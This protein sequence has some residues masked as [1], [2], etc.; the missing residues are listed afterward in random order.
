MHYKQGM[1]VHVLGAGPAGLY[2]AL[3]LKKAAPDVV[4]TVYERNAGGDTFGFGV[5]FSDETLSYLDDADAETAALIRAQFAHWTAVDT[6]FRGKTIR[7]EGH[8]FSGIERRE[9]LKILSDRAASLGAE[10]RFQTEVDPEVLLASL[11]PND[12]VVGADG[13]NSRLRGRLAETIVPTFDERKA[14]YIWLGTKQTFDAFVFAFAEHEAGLFQA[15]AYRF[16]GSR[17]DAPCSTF[18]VETSEETYQRAGLERMS[19]DAQ[20][21][22]L[23][24]LFAEHLGGHALE[25]NRSE[26]L[27][28][29]TLRC[30]AWSHKNVVFLGDAVH[31]AHF[32]IGSGTKLAMEDA[33]T[34]ARELG[35]L[36]RGKKTVAEAF[37]DYETERRLIVEKTQAAA[38]DSL[39]FFENTKRYAHFDP[40]QFV[41]R[42]MT[43][44]KRIGY[45]NLGL[46]DATYIDEVQS[47]FA[48]AAGARPHVP[49]M[50]TPYRL[51]EMAL[52]NRV[53]LSPMCMYRAESGT[54]GEAHLV[55]L[56]S[57]AVGGAGLLITE[58]TCPA[59]DA[60]ITPGCAGIY[61]DE[62][63][64]AWKRVVDFV[65]RESTTKICLQI[66]HAGR[67]GSTREP[68][69]G[70]DRPLSENNWP[71]IS[72]SAIAYAPHNQ[73]PREATEADLANV[74]ES[75]VE[76]TKRAELAGFD[77]I[78]LHAAHGYLLASF[79]SPLTNQRT[80]AYGGSIQNRVRYPLSVFQA[81][82]AVWP[83][84]KPMSV[85]ISATDWDDEGISEEDML[86]IATAFRDAGADILHVSTGQTTPDG[87]PL[88]Y[89]RM[90]QTPF[91]DQIRNETR[92]PT[93][94]VGNITTADQVN[95]ILA[96]G[97]A[98]LV[99]IAR[100][101]LRDPYFTFHAAEAAKYTEMTWPNMYGI[102]RV[103]PA[104]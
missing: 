68:W 5:V 25:S 35:Q 63:V 32:S 1:H 39:L 92:M 26:W 9:L 75:F 14:R 38:Q 6:T 89:G 49:P 95:T 60:R 31:T 88:F 65:H 29:R 96:A 40:W 100:G 71:L 67:K 22:F 19:P 66:G 51:R 46:R 24:R 87:R 45:E 42:L 70:Q 44:S 99:A 69:H 84:D 80:D 103:R 11:G 36:A 41:F 4:I 3:L 27:R 94:A 81:M 15:H 101:H 50:F 85:R 43:R 59:A 82:R 17:D 53:V 28:F 7:S 83:K 23:E 18:I 64:A 30:R 13:V 77:M 79:L 48:E 2:L 8:G 97:R 76:A 93:I 47:H 33:I 86:H 21:V 34:L 61:T 20:R 57:R 54:V 16:A 73:I 102:V 74:R 104:P 91:A 72:A 55:H 52:E 62:H 37:T 78:E 58:M 56:G 90:F 98:D 10:L 12:V